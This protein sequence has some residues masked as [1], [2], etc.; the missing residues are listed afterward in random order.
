MNKI[1]IFIFFVI[2]IGTLQMVNAQESDTERILK[3]SDDEKIIL[4]AGFSIAIIGIFLFLAR[5]I[6]LRK[7]TTYDKQE[8]ESKKIG[9]MKNIILIGEMTMKKLVKEEILNKKKNSEKD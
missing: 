9:H 1:K 5:D 3:I 4:F 6:I 8:H 7:K 2:M